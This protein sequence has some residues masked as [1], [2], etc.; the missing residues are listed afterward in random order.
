MKTFWKT[1]AILCLL[2]MPLSVVLRWVYPYDVSTH[3]GLKTQAILKLIYIA[4]L[5]FWVIGMFIATRLR[6][7]DD[8]K[9][10]EIE[11]QAKAAFRKAQEEEDRLKARR[12][13]EQKLSP[14]RRD[15]R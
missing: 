3:E 10:R 13:T 12:L 5:P 15:F 11:A 4:S 2:A 8:M 6:R 1:V 14:S 9:L 7:S